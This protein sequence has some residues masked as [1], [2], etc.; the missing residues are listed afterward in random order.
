M[1]C[2]F[3][4]VLIIISSTL[5]KSP[6]SNK[7]RI[8]L[9]L[10]F[11][12]SEAISKIFSAFRRCSSDTVKHITFLFNLES[13]L[14]AI[15]KKIKRKTMLKKSIRIL[16]QNLD[17]HVATPS[18]F[19]NPCFQSWGK[20]TQFP[21]PLLLML[22]NLRFCIRDL[23]FCFDS[24]VIQVNIILFIQYKPLKSVNSKNE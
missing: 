22:Y 11:V 1:L 4:S 18:A 15:K 12:L 14:I 8:K 7:G 9:K 5:L 17:F 24:P 13:L 20:T 10:I 2:G 21:L 16:L 19:N 23:Y 6:L 3:F